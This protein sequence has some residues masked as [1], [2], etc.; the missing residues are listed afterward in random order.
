MIR[1]VC[2][3]RDSATGLFG[4]PFFVTA[5]GQAIRIFSDE[6]QRKPAETDLA[7]HPED[8]ELFAIAEFDEGNG[9]FG[10]IG[11]PE[12]LIRGKDC[13]ATEH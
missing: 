6:V 9:R 5:R 13:L 8:F 12:P 1:L 10:G 4:Q 7:K 3:V 11:D 2:A